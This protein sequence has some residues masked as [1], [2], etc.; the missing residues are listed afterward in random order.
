MLSKIVITLLLA[1]SCHIG[2]RCNDKVVQPQE[3][4]SKVGKQIDVIITEDDKDDGD[5]IILVSF[6]VEK[7]TEEQI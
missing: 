1:L 4:S 7:E 3:Q 2:F 6:T 5:G